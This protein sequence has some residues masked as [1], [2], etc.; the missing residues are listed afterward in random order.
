MNLSINRTTAHRNLL[1][2]RVDEALYYV[3]FAIYFVKCALARTCFA[4][5]FFI[6]VDVFD[7]FAQLTALLLLFMKF[8]MQRAPFRCWVLSAFVVLVGF[9]SWR[10]SGEAWLFWVALFVVCANGTRL[11]PLAKITFALSLATL[12]VTVMS[13]QLGI[14]EN[15]VFRRGT[16]LRYALGFDHP[17]A[18]GCYV[19]SACVAFSA[20]RFGKNPAPDLVLIGIAF[21]LSL[22]VANSRATALLMIFQAVVLAV[23]YFVRNDFMRSHFRRCFV[24]VVLLAIGASFY[25]MVAYTPLNA[26]HATLNSMLS[27]RLYLAHGYYGMQPLTLMGT[28]FEGFAPIYW[29]SRTGEAAFVLDNAWCHLVLRFGIIPAALLLL[30][31]LALFFKSI[32]QREWDALLFGLLI[33]AVY[34]FSETVG[35]RVECNF[36]LYAIG[37]DLLYSSRLFGSAA[38]GACSHENRAIGS[39][40]ITLSS[41]SKTMR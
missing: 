2:M 3:A 33:M 10:Q 7:S 25:F 19:L 34:G 40:G 31:Y 1:N 23:F 6:S 39:S 22:T 17:N 26:F 18:F 28:T 35:I 38:P 13:A 21:V 8:V 32:E 11:L 37:A 29:S 36:F 27:G 41:V 5:F 30:G 15:W 20:M 14:I 16:V 12:V 9:V 24:G 4:E